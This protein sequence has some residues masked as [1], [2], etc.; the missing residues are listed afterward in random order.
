MSE[1]KNSK[2]YFSSKIKE[3]RLQHRRTFFFRDQGL[4][5]EDDQRAAQHKQ[6]HA[7]NSL[8]NGTQLPDLILFVFHSGPLFYP[9]ASDIACLHS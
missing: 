7:P 6:E 4:G 2:T 8:D 1:L 9:E 5:G 3:V